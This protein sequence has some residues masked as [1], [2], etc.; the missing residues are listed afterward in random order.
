V[1]EDKKTKVVDITNA[2]KKP[3]TKKPTGT[4]SGGGGGGRST[5]NREKFGKYAIKN[6][7]L[8]L[9]KI[10]RDGNEIEVL[11]V[12]ITAKI[13]EYVMLKNGLEEV[14]E[15]HIQGWRSNGS[16]LPLAKVADSVFSQGQSNW[17]NPKW[18]PNV[19]LEP[20]A[21]TIKHIRAAIQY[22]SAIDGDVPVRSVYQCSG[23]EKIDD[24]WHFLHGAGAI[25]AQGLIES[26]EVDLP[27]N[28]AKYQLPPPLAGTDL[29]TALA[30]A[31]QLPGVCPGKPQVGAALLCMALRAPLNE[32]LDS[33]FVLFLHG[34]TGSRKSSVAKLALGFH[35]LGFTP[36]G[37]RNRGFPG[38]WLS[39]PKAVPMQCFLAKDTVFIADDLKYTGGRT[40]DDLIKT[41]NDLI[42]QIGNGS[43]RDTLTADRRLRNGQRSRCTL[44]CTG[45][46]TPKTQSTFARMLTME[47]TRDDVDER[48]LTALQIA[49]DAG[50]FAGLM[51]AY[52]VWL[53]ANL[54][55][56]K[57]EFPALVVQLADSETARPLSISHPRAPGIYASLVAAVE[58]FSE[59]LQECDLM[60]FVEI[61]AFQAE[62][63]SALQLAFEGQRTYQ[64]DQDPCLRF[65]ELI[66]TALASG[67]AHL[68]DKNT[69]EAPKVRPH[70]CG[71]GRSGPGSEDYTPNGKRIG[72]FD[73]PKAPHS[74]KVYLLPDAA[75]EVAQSIAGRQRQPFFGGNAKSLWRMMM[76]RGFVEGEENRAESRPFKRKTI[77]GISQRVLVLDAGR[78]LP[79]GV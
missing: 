56:L 61:N 32:C 29:K 30:S 16:P 76:H 9:V 57:S 7:S 11:L 74:A 14:G 28:L 42:M 17:L 73:P 5:G 8:Y 45:E 40:D 78:L 6:G 21:T 44:I 62:I 38:N 41:A 48:S 50:Q 10:D 55:R 47:I 52:L 69:Q 77:D 23:W 64:D 70:A 33:D 4:G 20:G 24:Q 18:G 79:L 36:R 71:W 2:A 49:S 51:S 54:D 35:G 60:T 25:T 39:S 31:L 63:E 43:G 59:F 12:N 13:T 72:W 68:P 22:Y 46:D 1:S 66:Q 58:I 34:L 26:V 67:D 53:A 27:G 75:F 19:I 3:V 15:W 65:V 37:E